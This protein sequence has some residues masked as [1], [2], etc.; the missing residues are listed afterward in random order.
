MGLDLA[1][2]LALILAIRRLTVQRCIKPVFGIGSSYSPYGRSAY[3]KSF[4]YVVIS[5]TFIGFEQNSRSCQL[6]RLLLT[7]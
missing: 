6:A 5:P 1:I 4:R 2:Y 3:V 7:Y